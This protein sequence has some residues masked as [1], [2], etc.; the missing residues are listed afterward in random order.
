LAL[1]S[2]PDEETS[3]LLTTVCQLTGKDL[4]DVLYDF[5]HFVAPDLLRMYGALADPGWKT[6]DFLANVE[7]TI[8][9]I[10]RA[11]SAGAAPPRLTCTKVSA[12]EV[13]IDYRSPRNMC[14]FARGLIQ[15]VADHYRESVKISEVTCMH[16]GDDACLLRVAQVNR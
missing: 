4:T 1:N 10:V 11:R 7:T 2:Y 13:E 12:T 5:G 9:D 8:H 6:I 15:G 14:P 3:R 16:K